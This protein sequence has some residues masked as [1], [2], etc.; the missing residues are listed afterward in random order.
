MTLR[1]PRPT[2]FRFWT[3][4]SCDRA[5]KADHVIGRHPRVPGLPWRG[6]RRTNGRS[7]ASD[8]QAMN[9]S[10]G[11]TTVCVSDSRKRR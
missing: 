10:V 3:G 2:I 11:R 9:P 6:T 7:D 1:A 8:T 4:R 5:K